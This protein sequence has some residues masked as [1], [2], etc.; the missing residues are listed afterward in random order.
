M[1]MLPK[2]NVLGEE[3]PLFQRAKP[4]LLDI[5]CRGIGET[6][7]KRIAGAAAM[8]LLMEPFGWI[9]DVVMRGLHAL[10]IVGLWVLF[11]EELA[12][13]GLSEETSLSL[14]LIAVYY[15]NIYEAMVS[16]LQHLAIVATAG[17]IAHWACKGYLAR[18]P[19]RQSMFDNQT[20][21]TWTTILVAVMPMQYRTTYDRCMDLYLDS[22]DTAKEKDLE[23]L[24]DA[25][26]SGAIKFDE[27]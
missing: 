26:E 27:S 6:S 1:S 9:L 24:L 16:I 8:S 7:G 11:R 4:V 2:R 23:D 13:T 22:N 25:Y 17:G 20:V 18:A 21:Q 12:A 19:L 15:K 3:N 10:L 14:S 5:A